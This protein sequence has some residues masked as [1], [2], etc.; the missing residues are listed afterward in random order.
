VFQ[1]ASQFNVLEMVSPDVGPEAG[2]TGYQHDRTQGPACAMSCPAA[3]VFRCSGDGGC[4][5]RHN[6]LHLTLRTSHLTPQTSHLAPHTSHL[7]PHTSH[8]ALH[9][10]HLT[11][12]T[13]HLT[14]HVLPGTTSSTEQGRTRQSTRYHSSSTRSVTRLPP[15]SRRPPLTRSGQRPE[16]RTCAAARHA[17]GAGGNQAGL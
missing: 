11:P 1:V 3:T 16:G 10:S 6:T 8:L 15:P 17:A 14:P 2:V 5:A 7:T 4:L 9:T 13:S 12:H